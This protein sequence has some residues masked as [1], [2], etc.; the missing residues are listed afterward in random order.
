MASKNEIKDL[1]DQLAEYEEETMQ[2]QHQI[3]QLKLDKGQ[4][5][6]TKSTQSI[7]SKP[8]PMKASEFEEEPDK[9]QRKKF[10][11]AFGETQT[12]SVQRIKELELQLKEFRSRAKKEED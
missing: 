9:E 8:K 3:Y 2:L 10:M 4:S 12:E 6:P 5:S 11:E 7:S 1:Q